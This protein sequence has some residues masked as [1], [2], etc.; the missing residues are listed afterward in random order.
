MKK[1]IISLLFVLIA[2]LAFGAV[3][4]GPI[5]VSNLII[6]KNLA[7]DSSVISVTASMTMTDPGSGKTL[8]VS[9]LFDAK[10]FGTAA[11]MKAAI[12]K[13]GRAQV[14]WFR[15]DYIPNLPKTISSTAN[16]STATIDTNSI[17]N[18]P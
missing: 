9:G 17:S 1:Y 4:N 5:P 6:T 10:D 18:A 2:L 16:V 11:A 15:N 14:S 3:P 8:T 13:W 7:A 12:E